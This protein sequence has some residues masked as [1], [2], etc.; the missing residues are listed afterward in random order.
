MEPGKYQAEKTIAT[1]DFPC[2]SIL[3]ASVTK[4]FADAIWPAVVKRT[5]LQ[6]RAGA[7]EFLKGEVHSTGTFQCVRNLLLNVV[8]E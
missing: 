4:Q 2:P 1:S 8:N 3:L 6:A 7:R 5:R